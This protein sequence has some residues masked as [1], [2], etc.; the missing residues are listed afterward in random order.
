LFAVGVDEAHV[1]EIDDRWEWF[2]ACDCALPALF[3]FRN[4]G[5][6]Q[7][8]FDKETDIAVNE[9]SCNS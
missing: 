5:P 9:S 1:S 6:R 2:L 3:E 8:P 7:P 4:T